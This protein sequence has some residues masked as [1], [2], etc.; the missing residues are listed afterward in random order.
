MRVLLVEDDDVLGDA[1]NQSLIN[2]GYAV[3]WAKDGRYADHA[4]HDQVYDA[5]VLDLGL[6]KM[7]GLTVLQRLRQRKI[8]IP[9]LILSA[10]EG[11]D[12][13]IK[14]LDLGADDYLTKPF[15][16]KELEA[17]LR[18]LI[19]RANNSNNSHLIN[20]GALVLNTTERLISAHGKM[21]AFS[22]REFG[23]LELLMLRN[24]RAVSKEALI[25][26]LYNW[27]EEVSTNAIE[28]YI[29]RVRKKL[30]PYDIHINNISGLGYMLEDSQLENNRK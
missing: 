20:V 15:K 22:K 2:A 13:R 8:E 7:D 5:A 12:D 10:R 25:E 17:R 24:G 14:A 11:L 18:A 4:L 30:E 1:L 3:D 29:F 9:V 23:V 21:I 6:P 28:V 19:R 26:N 16:L 27:S